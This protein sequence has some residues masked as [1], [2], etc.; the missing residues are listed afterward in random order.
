MAITINIITFAVFQPI[1]EKLD[2]NKHDEKEDTP[3]KKI[4]RIPGVLVSIRA[5]M[6]TLFNRPLGLKLSL[7]RSYFEGVSLEIECC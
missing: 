6:K 3:K 4:M 7:T 1:I 5:A 2:C